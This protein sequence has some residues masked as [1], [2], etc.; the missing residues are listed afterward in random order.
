LKKTHVLDD[1][2]SLALQI[3]NSFIEL[4]EFAEILTPYA[5]EIR[6][7]LFEEPAIED[8]KRAIEIA[9]KIKEFILKRLPVK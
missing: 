4:I 7:P 9:A 2:I 3:D 6:Y 8:A 1:L 5:V